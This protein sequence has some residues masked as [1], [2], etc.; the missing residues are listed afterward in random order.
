MDGTLYADDKTLPACNLSA[1]KRLRANGVL[2][3]ITTGRD[4]WE[5][6]TLMAVTK[7]NTVVAGN[8]ATVLFNHHTV[9]QHY[10]PTKLVER[11]NAAAKRDGL[12]VAY[13]NEHHA[14]LSG[15]DSLTRANYADVQQ[16]QPVIDPD[17]DTTTP[18]TRMLLFIGNDDAG[19]QVKAAYQREF[20]EMAFYR[21]SP[22]DVDTISQDVS[23]AS[24]IAELLAQPALHGVPT[25]AFGDADNDLPLL[26]AVDHPVAMQNGTHKARHAAEFVTA[27][28][29]HK[30]IPKGLRHFA[31][32]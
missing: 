6:D 32:I 3:V 23:K 4:L 31:L 24:G 5:I 8:G 10:I 30:G 25:Y 26:D 21:D 18:L 19:N 17:F 28:N 12:K 13:Y 7:I 2:P 27:D 22:Y 14:V 29:M 1:I 16:V 20:P 15:N 11:I 9:G